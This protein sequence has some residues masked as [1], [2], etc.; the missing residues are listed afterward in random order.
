MTAYMA[1]MIPYLGSLYE[2]FHLLISLSNFKSASSKMHEFPLLESENDAKSHF[3]D[4][5]IPKVTFRAQARRCAS[6]QWFL[7]T[8]DR[9]WD[10]PERRDSLV[11]LGA[12]P[13]GEPAG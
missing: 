1:H 6:S 12:G 5:G 11:P 8:F 13:R 4:F 3:Y 9:P 7:N 10:F 2:T